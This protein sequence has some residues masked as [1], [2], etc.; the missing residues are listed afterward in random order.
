MLAT[1]GCSHM[2]L[3]CKLASCEVILHRGKLR[4]ERVTT[5]GKVKLFGTYFKLDTT[6]QSISQPS[7]FWLHLQT[8]KFTIV[9]G[10]WK[11]EIILMKINMG[12]SWEVVATVDK[13]I[14]R[15]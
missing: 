6:Q 9:T 15:L 12:K 8:S 10:V 14:H 3:F 13:R 11:M 1:P 5:V 7:R 2:L 4:A